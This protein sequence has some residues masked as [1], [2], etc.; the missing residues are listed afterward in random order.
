MLMPMIAIR[1]FH[2]KL[3]IYLRTLGPTGILNTVILI[4]KCGKMPTEKNQLFYSVNDYR[5]I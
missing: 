4:W 1:Q 3:F 2:L 5:V